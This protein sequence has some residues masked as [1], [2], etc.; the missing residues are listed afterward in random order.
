MK[1]IN[2]ILANAETKRL[3]SR[4]N[5]PESIVKSIQQTV[6][7]ERKPDGLTREEFLVQKIEEYNKR[8]S[9][10]LVSVTSVPFYTGNV[11][12]SEDTVFVFGSNP[13]GKHGAGSAKVA[14]NNFGAVYGQ[15]EGLQGN[16][17]ALPT[18]RIEAGIKEKVYANM[19]FSF[20]GRQRA[21]VVSSNTIEAIINGERTATT[22]YESDGNIE[23]LQQAQVGDIVKFIN[24]KTTVY[25]KVTKP[26][27]KLDPK[28]NAEE[29]SKKEG[30]SAQYFNY[31]VK[32]KLDEAYQMEFEYV[33]AYGERTVTP[34]EIIENI[35]KLYST[36]AANPNKKFKI[37]YR[38]KRHEV[39]LN[40]YSG[41][42]MMNMFLS[43]GTIPS[44]IIFSEEWAMDPYFATLYNE[45]QKINNIEQNKNRINPKF[46][47]K[48]IVATSG[49]GKSTIAD[50]VDIID[51]DFILANILDVPVALVADAFNIAA[52][53]GKSV[54]IGKRYAEAIDSYLK[55]GKTVITARLNSLP[56][57]DYIVYRESAEDTVEITQK[58]RDNAGVS[59]DYATQI[60]EKVEEELSNNPKEGRAI[61]LSKNQFLSDVIIEG[62]LKNRYDLEARAEHSAQ[63]K[64]L[65]QIITGF[66][67]E[68]GIETSVGE[69]IALE[70]D[71]AVVKKIV[72]AKTAEELPVEAGKVL[73]TM[74]LW[75]SKMKPIVAQMIQKDIEK[76]K[77]AAEEPLQIVD[78]IRPNGK[79]NDKAYAARLK[80]G[81][82][83]KYTSYIGEYMG[84]ALR[85][86]YGTRRRKIKTDLSLID[87]C[88][89]IIRDLIAKLKSHFYFIDELDRT[90][91]VFAK[92]ILANN[93]YYIK[94]SLLKPG[95]TTRAELVEPREILNNSIYSSE[96]ELIY[97]LN[98]HNIHL[99]GSLSMA[100]QGTVYRP[101]ENPM[102]DLDFVALYENKEELEEVLYSLEPFK[103]EKLQ[104]LRTI[105][106]THK[107]P[108]EGHATYTYIHLNVPF[109]IK[110]EDTNNT[111]K[112]E[113]L[114]PTTGEQIGYFIKSDLFIEKEGV[115][116]KMLDF[117]VEGK[118]SSTVLYK[119][120]EDK[121]LRISHWEN[122]VRAK[123]DWVR[124]K[125]LFD[126]N[127]F[128][129][130]EFLKRKK[131]KEKTIEK[132]ITATKEQATKAVPM[133][134]R[135]KMYRAIDP[136]L[137]Q[138]RY[139]RIA[140]DFIETLYEK[141]EETIEDLR[142]R[143]KETNDE[144]IKHNLSSQL[145]ELT[146]QNPI[147]AYLAHNSVNGIFQE[148][149]DIYSYY[150]NTASDKE[151][152]LTFRTKNPGGSSYVRTQLQLIVDHFDALVEES[153]GT[154]EEMS[155]L[156]ITLNPQV[157]IT[158]ETTLDV[159]ET[160][161]E[162]EDT[163]NIGVNEES[164]D[165]IG[166]KSSFKVRQKNN[167]QTLTTRIRKVLSSIVRKDSTG[168]IEQDDLG[169]ALYMNS[170]TAHAI[171][172]D[173]LS[174]MITSKDFVI[175][176]EDSE[177][178][179][180]Y[181][182]PA[183]EK[184]AKKYSW[185][186]QIINTLKS[187]P[188]LIGAF[189]SAY[190]KEFIKRYIYKKGIGVLPANETSIFD[191]AW[192][193][194][195]D[196]LEEGVAITKNA[197]YGAGVVYK[198]RA[199]DYLK[200]INGL[201]E[202]VGTVD[203]ED[204]KSVKDLAKHIVNNLAKIGVQI[205]VSPVVDMLLDREGRTDIK[206]A[207][208]HAYDI[209]KVAA[210]S[211]EEM[212][213]L[214]NKDTKSKY[215]NLLQALDLAND[216]ISEQMYRQGGKSHSSYTVPGYIE[217][218]FKKLKLYKGKA[219]EEFLDSEFKVLPFYSDGEW[220]NS[221]LKDLAS[222][223]TRASV[224]ANLDTA[225]LQEIDKIE[226]SKW[227]PSQI[228]RG[229]L[230]MF[231]DG[232]FA[233]EN[234]T[235]SQ[236]DY[237]WFNAP[238]LSDSPVVKFV[239][240][241]RY[242]KTVTKSLEDVM[243]PLFVKLVKQELLR[244]AH[245]ESREKG[246]A[247]GTIKEVSNYDKLG[248]DLFYFPELKEHLEEMK[249]AH[250]KGDNKKLEAII[251]NA[252]KPI[253]KEEF[254]TW[255]NTTQILKDSEVQR[256]VYEKYH[257][258]SEDKMREVLWDYYLNQTYASSQIIQLLV[259]DPAYY[260]NS[261]EFQKRFKEVYAAGTKLNTQTEYG[262]EY[263]KALI[264]KDRSGISSKL[265]VVKKVLDKAVEAG[266][267]L[268]MD[269]DNILGKLKNFCATDGQAIRTL[270]SLKRIYDMMGILDQVEDAL[271]R[272]VSGKWDMKDFYTVFQTLKP[273]IYTS[274][275]EEDG[276][277]G[278]M[279]IGHQEKDSE[280]ISLLY[281]TIAM[282]LNADS[283]LQALQDF[284]VEN[285][286]DIIV[287][288]SGVKT[289][290]Q[291]PIDI[292]DTPKVREAIDKGYFIV[293]NNQI[294]V[295]KGAQSLEDI[296][297]AIHDRVVDGD[298]TQEEANQLLDY[299]KPSYEEIHSILKKHI[300][301]KDESGN[302]IETPGVLKYVPTEDYS[303]TMSTASNHLVDSETVYGTQFNTLI[304]ADLTDETSITLGGREYKGKQIKDFYQSLKIENLL[305]NYNEV[306]EIFGSPEVLAR[307]I[308]KRVDSNAKYNKGIKEA[309]KLVQRKDPATGTVQTTF[310]VPFINP[311]MK[312]QLQEIVLSIFKNK[313][314]KQK[315]KGG[316]AFLVSDIGYT[317]ELQIAYKKDKDGNEYIDYIPCY[318]P[319]TAKEMFADILVEHSTL[320]GVTYSELDIDAKD[321]EGNYIV[322]R[323][324]L[325][326]IGY[327]IPTE[328]KYS[329]VPLRVVGFLPQ[330]NGSSIMLPSEAVIVFSGADYD[331]DKLFLMLYEYYKDEYN[332][333]KGKEDYDKL[334]LSNISFEDWWKQNRQ[335][336]ARKQPLYRKVN[337]DYS[338]TPDQNNRKQRNNA[339]IDVSRA[340]LRHPMSAEQILRPQGFDSFIRGSLITQIIENP[341]VVSAI[342]RERGISSYKKLSD[343]LLGRS[344]KELEKF[345]KDYKKDVPLLSP[346]N[347][348]HY[349][350]QNMAGDNS[351]G[352][353]A[354]NTTRQAKYQ[355]TGLS[356]VESF[357]FNG[358]RIG[359]LDQTHTVK[360]DP[361][362]LEKAVVLITQ[363]CC[364]GVGASADNAKQPTI[365]TMRQRSGLIKLSAFLMSAGVPM[366][367]VALFF[368]HPIVA[369]YIDENNTLDGLEE[370]LGKEYKEA[371]RDLDLSTLEFSS[372]QLL[373]LNLLGNNSDTSE[374]YE[375]FKQE[376][377]PVIKLIAKLWRA[378]NALG[379]ITQV[380]RADSSNGAI[381]HTLGIAST[382]RWLVDE[383]Q[384]QSTKEGYPLTGLSAVPKNHGKNTVKMSNTELRALFSKS[385]NPL[386]QA[387][388]TLGIE[389]PQHILETYF[390]EM[391]PAM[392]EALDVVNHD[393]P[394]STIDSTLAES[395]LKHYVI[396]RLGTF[397]L[398]RSKGDFMTT[399]RYYLN[400]FPKEFKRILKNNKDIADI[401]V[402][403]RL[404]LLG[405][406]KRKDLRLTEANTM[407]EVEA[408]RLRTSMDELLYM[409]N[410]EA[411]Q[412]AV[413][414]FVYTYFSNSLSFLPHS[415][416]RFFSPE[417]L[418][419]IPGYIEK[420]YEI[421]EEMREGVALSSYAEY[422][423]NNTMRERAL[424]SYVLGEDFSIIEDNG[425]KHYISSKTKNVGGE[426]RNKVKLKKISP[427]GVTWSLLQLEETID[428]EE[429]VY[430]EIPYDN[431]ISFYNPDISVE[432]SSEILKQQYQEDIE[433]K[434]KEIED[435]AWKSGLSTEN[436]EEVASEA[437]EE[438]R[439]VLD[440]LGIEESF[441]SIF[442]DNDFAKQLSEFEA[443]YSQ[444][445]EENSRMCLNS[446]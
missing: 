203:T 1:G 231:L 116:G 435:E 50:N 413:D 359:A 291:G 362:T 176:S 404:H 299:F 134:K 246:I 153:L 75:H 254:E 306:K 151:L 154:I 341:K 204:N 338:K 136:G 396:Y 244:I 11:A 258:N 41:L 156:S 161:D 313:I 363:L 316:T 141:I 8:L 197:L 166:G 106:D 225:E 252:L 418:T 425:I 442:Y 37:G 429:A 436:L 79:I 344:N 32:P 172:L 355:G 48:L 238:I 378:S 220:L 372:S 77:E 263:Q 118:G 170:R 380:S 266:R 300:Y 67:E 94:S 360:I 29:W 139:R 284:A 19:T 389:A 113:L 137:R 14:V 255:L 386:L 331:I 181:S 64:S 102:H 22:R 33:G 171:L 237:T 343:F 422:W 373:E 122:S 215:I 394:S 190:R 245:V 54:E 318:L 276:L 200:I 259:T 280:F 310:A 407:T 296:Q 415:L 36:A 43:A 267:I 147:S 327:R 417:F 349:H 104:H 123:I 400:E 381:G 38:N 345:L 44:N 194:L 224:Q 446:R 339:L 46:K 76:E 298:I 183:L 31:N 144:E 52:K 379:L 388:Y 438:Q 86:E 385:G 90:S 159:Q 393:A 72:Q 230:A 323:K 63:T 93:P 168:N 179:I 125:D 324:L 81:G 432:E 392:Q 424:R 257:E 158:G 250:A 146:G 312:A 233:G 441:N 375:R 322:D 162:E 443:N 305:E 223:K 5:L 163:E 332:K 112:G 23:Y 275:M 186:K 289:G 234:K 45:S 421:E 247:N 91:R 242:K 189:Y 165:L 337:Y 229:F 273:F 426:W 51:G 74:S 272:I 68:F 365:S 187:T 261:V 111:N 160:Q 213:S 155:G 10:N 437:L 403:K 119:V 232:D 222:S 433:A 439:A 195:V 303:I 13:E 42:E 412:L 83:K 21:D 188:R 3:A 264:V 133:S 340:I 108:K 78:V 390:S 262:K 216:T 148:I 177:G 285:D 24:G 241:K 358:R 398:F 99:A 423:Y 124:L 221:V 205:N 326:L 65:T 374:E 309:V 121:T 334:Q 405:K 58:D 193:S 294:N 308:I 342:K 109:V 384:R 248:K 30:W 92:H 110:L 180:S 295:P 39:T 321:E 80:Y 287:F 66:L 62:E 89:E 217:V 120:S 328:H 278:K 277:G 18:K 357:I 60:Q 367:D 53:E 317:D 164:S 56:V 399:R 127:R 368:A 202:E 192:K 265:D 325:D 182:F 69:E 377:Y 85:D 28:T 260:K 329:M 55:Q 12:P 95:S 135:Q 335:N 371:V 320:A 16:S 282:S 293:G 20:N 387:F 129:S 174:S 239:K 290:S 249:E 361:T 131:E 314:T 152:Q 214:L 84:Q 27:T 311:T 157:T 143:I 243:M 270:P 410:P 219:L 330:Q 430:I 130:N 185:V 281:E 274:L 370:S 235:T 132:A 350:S 227:T 191:S 15:G 271:D 419:A 346:R 35:K 126:Y 383:I 440:Q 167:Y 251:S 169:T 201:E 175:K 297:A 107:N 434:E 353:Y 351:L 226:Y 333:K 218:L 304:V 26:L 283:E 59:L 319:C 348:I 73:A 427:T 414:L 240:L 100:M 444:D 117:F 199:A 4:Y 6:A 269:R 395:F 198:D 354:N 138:F 236:A 376:S 356:S 382:Q 7:S 196:K 445:S 105:V 302:T 210:E 115:K 96:K 391:S 416:T 409:D 57:A 401:E 212:P 209:A 208:K 406:G 173:K 47:G 402:L 49:T 142:N 431:S 364:E 34:K 88:I 253:L 411:Q 286:I 292:Y 97:L 347:F 428:N 40:G 420:L 70:F 279:R 366:E 336:Y 228:A 150:V 301:T 87:K 207:L 268:K 98:D 256:M 307:E 9:S 82:Y 178:N 128:I 288:E 101:D 2:C 369:D 149:K 211:K 184:M 397:D 145:S 103:G 206:N 352:A 315:I 61:K 140:T 408:E 114:D 25:V 17:Y 71:A